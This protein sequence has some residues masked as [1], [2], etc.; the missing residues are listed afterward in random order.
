MSAVGGNPDFAGRTT[1]ER[2][3]MTQRGL[4]PTLSNFIQTRAWPDPSLN[5]LAASGT[6]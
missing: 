2:L 3:Q 1:L 5:R 4:Q 6:R